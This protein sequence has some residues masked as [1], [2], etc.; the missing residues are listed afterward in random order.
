MQITSEPEITIVEIAKPEE[1]IV[2][3]PESSAVAVDH[4]WYD[5]LG[6]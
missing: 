4:I 6:D 3:K 5:S 1:E 2:V